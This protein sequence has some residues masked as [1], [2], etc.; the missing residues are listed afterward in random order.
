MA[1]LTRNWCDQRSLPFVLLFPVSLSWKL[2]KVNMARVGTNFVRL[3]SYHPRHG[4]IS[5]YHF[6]GLLTPVK[7]A[8]LPPI[9]WLIR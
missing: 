3:M 6:G 7:S 5:L 2:P 1:A 9:D 8:Y 4:S